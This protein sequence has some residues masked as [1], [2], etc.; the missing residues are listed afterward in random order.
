[1]R[2]PQV[3]F[4]LRTMMISVAAVAVGCAAL[5]FLFLAPVSV[6]TAAALFAAVPLILTRGRNRTLLIGAISLGCLAIMAAS[7]S[8]IFSMWQKAT[9]YRQLA[10]KHAIRHDLLVVNIPYFDKHP[11]KSPTIEPWEEKRRQWMNF[12]DYDARMSQK[13]DRAARYPVLSVDPDPRPWRTPGFDPV[14]YVN[15]GIE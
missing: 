5:P 13:Y 14:L 3:R 7:A 15:G 9:H 10:T 1:M 8:E 11:G 4:T 2:L 12:V 6:L